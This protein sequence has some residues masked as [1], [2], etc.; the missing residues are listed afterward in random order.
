MT[1]GAQNVQPTRGHH[2]FM[3]FPD[4]LTELFDELAR[5]FIPLRVIIF[6]FQLF[7]GQAFRQMLGVTAEH[8]VRPAPGH[9]GG[10]RHGLVASRLRDD[11]RLTLMIFGVQD[12][13]GDPLLLEHFREHFGFLDGDGA[14]QN[15]LAALVEFFNLGDDS[16]KFLLD[17]FINAISM[18]DA[19]QL[20]VGGYGRHV[21]IVDLLELVGL[22]VRGPGHAGEFLVHAEII[23]EGD[24]RQRLVLALDSD[25]FFGLDRLVQTVG[26]AASGHQAP[27]KFIDDEDLTVTH[28]IFDVLRKEFFGL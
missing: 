25:A 6:I 3:F 13:M 21:K 12:L 1:L 11:M 16:M 17:R 22:R 28:D 23:L 20:A 27:G 26:P 9:I 10:D 8:N 2:L 5:Q 15:R 7:L 19:L 4:L 14:H 24:G 18:I